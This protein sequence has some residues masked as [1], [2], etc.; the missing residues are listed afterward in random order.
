MGAMASQNTSLTIVY[1]TAYSCA[2][3]KKNSKLRITG[4]YAGNSPVTGEFPAHWTASS[5]ENVSIWWRHHASRMFPTLKKTN[6]FVF[7]AMKWDIVFCIK[8]IE[9]RTVTICLYSLISHVFQTSVRARKFPYLFA[10]IFSIQ[11]RVLHNLS[12]RSFRANSKYRTADN[13]VHVIHISRAIA[14]FA[15]ESQSSLT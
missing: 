1:S 7:L 14:T 6:K 8:R 12:A 3:Q 2:D 9:H 5:A 11:E 13:E 15:L 10:R 4:L